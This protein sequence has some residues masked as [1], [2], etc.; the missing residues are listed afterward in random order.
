MTAYLD[1]HHGT[2]DIGIL[3]GSGDG[4]AG[5]GYGSE[6]WELLVYRL[7]TW[8]GVRKVTCGTVENNLAMRRI[9]EKSGMEPD[10]L[11]RAQQLIHGKAVDVVHYALFTS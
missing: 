1:P 9:A 2:A 3:I 6:A 5:Q 4:L 11:R 10:G 8:P 7:L